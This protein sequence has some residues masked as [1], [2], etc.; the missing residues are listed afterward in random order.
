MW[1]LDHF[2]NQ[3]ALLEESGQS[4]S[5]AQLTQICNTLLSQI[6]NKGLDFILCE[7]SVGSIFSYV[8]MILKRTPILLLNADIDPL[9]LKEYI[10]TYSP[11]YLWLP[12]KSIFNIS[13]YSQIY[14]SF[15]Y[16]LLK[17]QEYFFSD[18]Y[19]ELALL[20]TTSGSTGSRK[21][22]RLS[23]KNIYINQSAIAT[24]LSMNSLDR[25]IT[26][27]PMNYSY[28]LSIINSVLHV[29]G[30][31]VVT[32]KS[33]LQKDFW[34]QM[35]GFHVTSL[36]GVPYTYQMLDRIRFYKMDLPSLVT[37]TQA[38][39]RLEQNIQ[40]KLAVYAQDTGRKFYVMYGQ[41]EATARL[42]CLPYKYAIR[43]LGSIGLPIPGVNI[44][45]LNNYGAEIIE[46]EIVGKLVYKGG[47][48]MLGYAEDLHDLALGDT[49]GGINESGDL[50]KRDE[51]GY[52]Y[53][54][55]REKRFLKI[56]GNR[57]NLDELERIIIDKF[58]G[59]NVACSGRDDML[60]IFI[61]G[62]DIFWSAEIKKFIIH[63]LKINQSG[64]E[65]RQITSFPKNESGKILYGELGSRF[66]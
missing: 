5:Y 56:F 4:Y 16:I 51:E 21:L 45:L 62:D 11:Q 6:N 65:I 38:G 30:S 37:L 29:G 53:I 49:C 54:V 41:T 47:N 13:G 26:T 7:N 14:A 66:T 64:F 39:G 31:L 23:Y 40:N 19:G 25:Y 42:C 59:C 2:K 57:V 44:S 35:K 33:V 17:K 10:T 1:P 12:E 32:K 24:S 55:G 48:V 52:I 28:G 34:D 22:V 36:G 27:L 3:I 15:N 18:L 58:P 8:S 9:L 50:A 46:S 63:N 20:L 60:F 43:K 61:E